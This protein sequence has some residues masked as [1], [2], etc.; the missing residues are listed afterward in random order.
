MKGRRPGQQK[1]QHRFAREVLSGI[2]QDNHNS[3]ND[4]FILHICGLSPVHGELLSCY[5]QGNKWF[6]QVSN[7]ME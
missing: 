1:A 7:T 6:V 2:T 3:G 5:E 4:D